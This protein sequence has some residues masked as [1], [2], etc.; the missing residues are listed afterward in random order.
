MCTWSLS[1]TVD[2]YNCRGRT[3]YGCAMDCSKAFDM[4]DWTKLFRQLLD[5]GISPILLRLIMFVYRNQYCDVRWNGKFSNRFPVSNGVR[6]GAVSSPI[7]FCI[8]VDNLIKELRRSDIGCRIGG[9]Y[10]GVAV[11]ADDIFLLS[12]SRNGLQC[13]VDIC[14]TFADK[15]NLKFSTNPDTV[16]SKTKCI[17]FSPKANE[18]RGLSPI[19]L[20]GISLPWVGDLK[21]LGN[22]VQSD[23]SMVIDITVKRAQFIGKIH[24][25]NQEFH[26]CHPDVVMHLYNIYTCSFY[27]SSLYDLYCAKLDQLYKTWNKT[28]RIL[29]NVPMDTHT[30]L[31]ESISKSLHPKVMLCSRFINFHK[32]NL[33]CSK[34]SVQFLARL[35]SNDLR[36]K[37]GRNLRNISE[38]CET[39]VEALT[40]AKVKMKMKYKEVP[41]NERWRTNLVDELLGARFATLDIPLSIEEREAIISFACSS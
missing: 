19:N 13:M 7:L 38:D 22:T 14:Q 26:F 24:S 20:G 9:H 21:H 32:I 23:N 27:S 18:R 3:V 4:V 16:K 41:E 33:S 36:T 15:S 10:L 8:Y 2:Y 37:Y 17:V 25:L 40:Q 5:R 39:P 30:Y 35:S 11:Y 31:I 28:V 29:Y 34:P 1:A 12:A 6:Q